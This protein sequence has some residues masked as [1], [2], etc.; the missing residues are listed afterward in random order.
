[1]QNSRYGRFKPVDLCHSEVCHLLRPRE[2]RPGSAWTT[3][4][5]QGEKLQT[6][7]RK[8]PL[9]SQLLMYVVNCELCT[10]QTIRNK[11]SCVGCSSH[12]SAIQR[13]SVKR[14]WSLSCGGPA[15]R[16]GV[17]DSPGHHVPQP[18]HADR[19]RVPAAGHHSHIRVRHLISA[20]LAE[21]ESE[22]EDSIYRQVPNR[23]KTVSLHSRELN[24]VIKS[25]DSTYPC[26]G[27]C[28]RKAH[29]IE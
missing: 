1:M 3:E 15:S 14:K 20:S 11:L 8:E 9:L 29:G 24:K 18:K 27:P 10:E 28:H 21:L 7:V 19:P 5:R 2:I 26:I 25:T 22:D 23:Q 4:P 13:G 6:T 12:G 17:L 16:L